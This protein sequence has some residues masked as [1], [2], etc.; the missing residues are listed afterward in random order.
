MLTSS[1][2]ADTPTAWNITRME[3]HT[4]GLTNARPVVGWLQRIILLVG[5]ATAWTS[6][7][8]TPSRG[9]ATAT[10][11]VLVLGT[12]VNGLAFA[13]AEGADANVRYGLGNVAR[14]PDLLELRA[15]VAAVGISGQSL[16]LQRHAPPE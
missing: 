13:A 14:D 7:R 8:G 4:P 5:A 12:V 1:P 16:D 9:P 15:C 10:A 3:E 11:G 2:A 6:A